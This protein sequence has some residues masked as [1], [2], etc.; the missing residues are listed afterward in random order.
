MPRGAL[1]SEPID[2]GWHVDWV[3]ASSTT[4]A[5]PG[6]SGNAWLRWGDNGLTWSRWV[7]ARDGPVEPFTT[8][9]FVQAMVTLSAAN[10]SAVPVVS[11]LSV[12]FSAIREVAVSVDGGAAW[13]AML[14]TYA[15][16]ASRV[17]WSGSVILNPGLNRVD[18]RA[19]D[20]TG[21]VAAWNITT[22]WDT[23][24]PPP[25]AVTTLPPA[26]S[27]AA[28]LR[29][30]WD[31]PVDVG[32]GVEEYAI[33]VGS[34]AGGGDLI[35]L[36]EVGNVTEYTLAGALDGR[37]YHFSVRAKDRAGNWGPW[38]NATH[39]TTVDRT[40]PGA[41]SAPAPAPYA[42]TTQ[43]TWNWTAFADNGSGV[44]LYE[45]R[46]GTSMAS[47]DVVDGAQVSATAF[48]LE[49][50]Q[51]GNRYY[52]SLRAADRAGNWGP[53]GAPSDPVAVDLVAPSAPGAPQGPTGYHNL[54][55]ASWNWTEAADFLAGVASY[56]VE[57]GTAPAGND[58][59]AG[60]LTGRTLF[61]TDLPDGA[62]IYARVRAQDGAGNF[63][64]WAQA[65]EPL[66]VDRSAP[67]APSDLVGP[68]E[69][70]NRTAA[71]WQWR[72]PADGESGVGYHEVRVGTFAGGGDLL[73]DFRTGE[74]VYTFPA[75]VEDTAIY[76]S[77][78]AVDR[79]GNR[80]AWA[81]SD[82]VH[83]DMS[84]PTSPGAITAT[85]SPARAD[86]LEWSWAPA[87]DSGSGVSFYLVR[88]GTAPARGDVVDWTHVQGTRFTIDGAQSGQ[89]Y[90]FSVRAVDA[91]GWGSRDRAA[92]EA[93]LVD[94]EAP[95]APEA[96]AASPST[97]E[98]QADVYWNL[99]SDPGGSGLERFEVA[100]G[101][102]GGTPQT[103]EASPYQF[104]ISVAGADGDRVEVRVRATDR[105]G[106][107]GPWSAPAVVLFDRSAPA[108]PSA[109]QARVEGR[110]VTWT[111]EP[112]NDTGVG[113]VEYVVTVGSAPGLS[114]I[115]GRTL[116]N[117]TSF[118]L[119][120]EPGAAYYLRVGALDGL[121]NEASSTAAA[122]G[123]EL[124]A[125][126]L[127]EMA[128]ALSA[129]ALGSAGVL[130]AVRRRRHRSA[131][132]PGQDPS[133]EE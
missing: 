114:D 91:V 49:G 128:A 72:A 2:A 94:L 97:R 12:R 101:A 45:V 42:N 53:W 19:T 67:P 92:E 40:P 123:V 129:L 31:A 8:S 93:V 28:D 20:T 38:G 81:T 4:L 54:T 131:P 59:F 36:L 10:W 74:T 63:G 27:A 5:P 76:F 99:V 57:V 85:S 109:A 51:H 44:S 130:I 103:V 113:A 116:T 118:S 46:V 56:E 1:L 121:G 34:L 47:A 43:I 9:R 13:D 60:R 107:T 84:P 16:N 23:L 37:A 17:V 79:A 14:L 64:P 22:G 80:G 26:Y 75:L 78:R 126:A 6:T 127:V 105:A 112:S 87:A 77:V 24:A 68:V 95:P 71:T 82:P 48:T 106:N 62:S 132:V 100:Y 73:F 125:F 124:P 104:V 50:A 66:R 117:R 102:P 25:P 65:Q 88:V 29:W 111:W 41:G 15:P 21:A 96:W 122:E 39:G 120:G 11:N 133:E 30:A 3:G 115:V 89:R 90:H 119:V 18:A 52:L 86:T 35:P 98:A 55:Q 7:R 69:W 61:L 58:I 83:V 110:T 108:P 33:R 32:L 70:I